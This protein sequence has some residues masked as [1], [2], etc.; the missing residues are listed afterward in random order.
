MTFSDALLLLKHYWAVA[1][2]LPIACACAMLAYCWLT[3][4]PSYEASAKITPSDPSGSLATSVLL[5]TLTP[6]A[7]QE[8]VVESVDGVIVGIATAS[9]TGGSTASQQSLT[10]IARGEDSAA[11]VASVNETA[12]R[13]VD[14]ITQLYADMDEK[15]KEETDKSL[16]RKTAL[17]ESLDTEEA[18]D[19]IAQLDATYDRKYEYCSFAIEE[20]TSASGGRRDVLSR[21]CAAFLVGV[22]LALLVVIVIDKVVKPIRSESDALSLSGT[23][24]LLGSPKKVGRN[25]FFANVCFALGAVPKTI[26]FVPVGAVETRWAISHFTECANSENINTRVLTLANNRANDLDFSKDNDCG[27]CVLAC[28]PVDDSAFTLYASQN[29]DGVILCLETWKS[30]RRELVFALKELRLAQ[31]NILG[32]AIR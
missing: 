10:L 24:I 18:I 17:L 7:E 28:E 31:A 9:V 19:R 4:V 5:S 25:L 30:G 22:M 20:A 2:V 14:R 3:D 29:A 13:T 11:C 15:L 6:I 23:Q 12:M 1:V 26:A 27:I 21:C 8:A 32:I 16:E